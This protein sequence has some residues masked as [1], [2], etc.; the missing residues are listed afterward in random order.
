MAL[1]GMVYL[2]Y[3]QSL[4]EVNSAIAQVEDAEKEKAETERERRREAEKHAGQLKRSLDKE[5]RANEALRKSE[6]DLQ[7]AALH[8]S[9]RGWSQSPAPV[10]TPPGPR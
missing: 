3:R 10:P 5:E 1:F 9:L 2:T 7:H 6:R 4:S 8:D